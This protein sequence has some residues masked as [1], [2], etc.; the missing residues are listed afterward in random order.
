MAVVFENIYFNSLPK[1]KILIQ[2]KMKAFADD[3][4]NMAAKLKLLFWKGRKI[5]L[6]IS[7]SFFSLS[8]FKRLFPQNH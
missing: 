8:V 4:L 6:V 7:I 1:D 2:S 5:V 3:K